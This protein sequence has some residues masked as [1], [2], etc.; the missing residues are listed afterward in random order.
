MKPSCESQEDRGAGSSPALSLFPTGSRE[1]WVQMVFR[2]GWEPR[3][4]PDLSY[5]KDTCVGS[6]DTC[7]SS[8]PKQDL[9]HRVVTAIKKPQ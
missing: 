8:N 3:G 9:R 6:G 5:N 4:T 2:W 1:E 7:S